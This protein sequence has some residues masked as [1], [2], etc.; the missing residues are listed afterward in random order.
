V[1]TGIGLVLGYAL[2]GA[3]WLVLKSEGELRDWAYARIRWLAAGMLVVLGLAVTLTLDYSELAKGHWHERR[4]GLV[5]PAIGAIALLGL[6]RGTRRRRYDG[7]PF[8]MTVLF[9]FASFATPAVLFWPYLIPYS[10]TIARRRTKRRELPVLW[11]RHL[12]AAGDCD[13]HAT[14]V[15]NLRGKATKFTDA[16][17][18]TI[19]ANDKNAESQRLQS[20]CIGDPVEEMGTLFG[21]AAVGYGPRG[22]QRQRQRLGLLQPRPGPLPCLPLGRRWAGWHLDEIQRLCFALALSSEGIRRGSGSSGS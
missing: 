11:R 18:G 5:F 2:L 13:L 19:N 9:F 14:E 7:V 20:Q 6:V 21:R 16:T 17:S 4:W 10:I 1:L 8:A 22:L 15:L 3:G 12:H